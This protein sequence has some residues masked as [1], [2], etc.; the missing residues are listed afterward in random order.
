MG[1]PTPAVSHAVLGFRVA[2]YLL[3]VGILLDATVTTASTVQWVTGLILVG[4]IPP[5]AVLARLR[6]R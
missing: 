5:E 6:R 3:G 1:D 2:S 4:V